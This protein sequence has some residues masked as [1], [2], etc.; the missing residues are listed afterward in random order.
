[1]N[2]KLI[3]NITTNLIFILWTLSTGA[4]RSLGEEAESLLR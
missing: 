2:N 4:H 1:M 3:F